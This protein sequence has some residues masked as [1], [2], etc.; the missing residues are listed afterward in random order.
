MLDWHFIGCRNVRCDLKC[1][2]KFGEDG[3]HHLAVAAPGGVEGDEGVAVPGGDLPP[4]GVRH[5]HPH[6]VLL[7]LAGARGDRGPQEGLQLCRHEAR[8]PGL[9]LE[10]ARILREYCSSSRFQPGE[11]PSRGLLLDYEPSGGPF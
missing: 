3:H 1:S 4:P 8:D 7:L 9:E 11:G 5:H 6:P 10:L 2:C